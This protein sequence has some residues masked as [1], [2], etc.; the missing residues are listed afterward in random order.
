MF[1]K[2]FSMLGIIIVELDSIFVNNCEKRA[3]EQFKLYVLITE[4]KSRNFFFL[5]R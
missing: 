1:L 2:V 4:E 5:K 3:G